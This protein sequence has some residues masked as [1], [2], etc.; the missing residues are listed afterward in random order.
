MHKNKG[1]IF[2]V[3]FSYF[4]YKLYSIQFSIEKFII[5]G[6]KP[7]SMEY[8]P[9]PNSPNLASFYVFNHNHPIIFL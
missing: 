9:Q 8:S 3:Y 5:T 4:H 1:F 2:V 7:Q 6:H